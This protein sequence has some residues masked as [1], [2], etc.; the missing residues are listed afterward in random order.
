MMWRARMRHVVAAC[1]RV[2]FTPSP[3]LRA[4]VAASLLASLA[5]PLR[6]AEGQDAT[7]PS[8]TGACVKGDSS[9]DLS[10]VVDQT[11]R[12]RQAAD[13]DAAARYSIPFTR[14]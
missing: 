4:L 6:Q 12:E 9:V 10:D 14:L 1:V 8:L 13:G 3:M 7:A 5:V 11:E 2:P